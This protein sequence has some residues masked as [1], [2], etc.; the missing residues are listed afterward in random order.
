MAVEVT[1]EQY[2]AQGGKL[3]EPSFGAQLPKAVAAV[4][5][6]IGVNEVTDEDKYREAVFAAIDVY[7]DAN[8]VGAGFT[9]GT[10]K[11]ERS[12]AR[13]ARSE[14]MVAAYEVLATTGMVYMGVC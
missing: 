11:M 2:V 9:I 7:A 5:Y 1:Y 6:L 13:T 10:F 3:P 8:P 12:S 14:A 4:D